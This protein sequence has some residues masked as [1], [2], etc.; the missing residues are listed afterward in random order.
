[1]DKLHDPLTELQ[2]LEH[3]NALLRAAIDH[4]H[5]TPGNPDADAIYATDWYDDVPP[6]VSPEPFGLTLKEDGR[7]GTLHHGFGLEWRNTI[8][9]LMSVGWRI[10]FRNHATGGWDVYGRSR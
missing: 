7:R 5:P 10:V 8:F 4:W 2:R 1:M 9:V 6:H 3:E